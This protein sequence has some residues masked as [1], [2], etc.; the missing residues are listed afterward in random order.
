MTEHQI[1]VAQ[2]GNEKPEPGHTCGDE[3]GRNDIGENCL[4][5][6]QSEGEDRTADRGG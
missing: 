1:D 5:D 3:A 6:G 2:E 4:P